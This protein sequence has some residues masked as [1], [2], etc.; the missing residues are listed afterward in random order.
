MVLLCH[1]ITQESDGGLTRRREKSQVENN[2]GMKKE[3][4]M[5][6]Q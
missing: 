3:N 5:Y 2:V 6:I 1:V 4:Q